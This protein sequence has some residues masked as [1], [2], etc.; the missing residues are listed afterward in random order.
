MRKKFDGRAYLLGDNIGIDQIISSKFIYLNEPA[1]SAQHIFEESKIK[2]SQPL[3]KG[4]I[5]V[6]G[7]NF[8]C[9]AS[10]EQSAIA[11]K[12]AGVACIMAA[13]F[14]RFFY[15]SAINQGIPLIENAEAHGS[16]SDGEIIDIDLEN[17][18]IICKKDILKFSV[19]PEVILK[20]LSSGGLIPLVK[21]SLGK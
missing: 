15:R 14:G 8:G 13:S 9:G 7:D 11:L 5:I 2:L 17:C 10:R 12:A 20:I 6:A 19:L 16:I 21:K 18:E 3:E 4:C 1:E